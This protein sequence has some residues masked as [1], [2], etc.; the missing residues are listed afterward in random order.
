MVWAY[1][2]AGIPLDDAAV[3]AIAAAQGTTPERVRL[4]VAE[5]Q[6]A[7]LG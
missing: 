3:A 4:A 5:M 7:R 6:A 2:Y 1:M